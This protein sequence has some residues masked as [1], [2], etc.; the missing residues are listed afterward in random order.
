[1]PGP[2]DVLELIRSGRATTRGE[3]LEI[4]GLSRMTVAARID[5]LLG[6]GFLVENGT[7]RVAAG[8]PSRRLQFNT[9]RALLIA[10]TADTTHTTVA[11]TD[12]AGRV[13]G[14]A[15]IDVAIADGPGAVLGTIA[16]T[17]RDLLDRHGIPIDRI[18]GLGISVPGPVDPDTGRPSQPPIMPGWDAYPVPEHL[19]DALGVPVLVANDADAAA[20]GEQRTAHPGSRSLCFIK[21]SSGIGTGIVIGGQVYRG[22]DGGAGDIGHVKIPGHDDLVCQCGAH[23]CLAAVASGRALARTLTELGKPAAS[24]SDVAAYLAAGDGDAARLTQAAGRVI[25]EVVATVVSLL[26]P[27]EVVI[28]GTLAS[29]PLITGIRETLYPR[30]LPR[31]TRHL[32]ISQ[33]S[34]GARAGI[35]GIATMVT[36]RE[37][38]AAAVNSALGG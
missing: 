7:D 23:G 1:M 34:L 38:S 18:G 16:D 5:A 4:T 32:S 12:L 22:A 15:R 25:G 29:A 13:R 14:E 31:A 37:Y 36:E 33:S 30:S 2:G 27:A 20:L 17:A 28:G 26:N 9:E 3:V 21:V 10:A 6:A 8:R 19:H 35:V 11:L 24:A